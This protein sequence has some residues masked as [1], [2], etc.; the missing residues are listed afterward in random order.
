MDAIE[1]EVERFDKV[2]PEFLNK[3]STV[4]DKAPKAR[5][6]QLVEDLFQQFLERDW[7][8]NFME[9]NHCDYKCFDKPESAGYKID[10]GLV[11]LR[12]AHLESSTLY[13]NVLDRYFSKFK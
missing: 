10:L 1:A 7:E 12:N 6:K 4:R 13:L 5:Y 3:Y 2:Y 9:H 8:L 11:R